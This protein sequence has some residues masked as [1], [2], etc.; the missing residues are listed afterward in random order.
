MLPTYR[1][2]R[3]TCFNVLKVPCAV[4]YLCI[5]NFVPPNHSLHSRSLDRSRYIT[6]C[7]GPYVNASAIHSLNSASDNASV[8]VRVSIG[9][10]FLNTPAMAFGATAIAPTSI[11]RDFRNLRRCIFFPCV[12]PKLIPHIK[13]HHDQNDCH[14]HC[15]RQSDH[16]T[17]VAV[18]G[19]RP[20]LYTRFYQQ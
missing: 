1:I 7:F 4:L 9:G 5:L 6:F 12:F 2:S 16:Y 13:T 8:A 20:R 19:N 10:F 3:A 11:P 15:Q 14:C 18:T 17:A